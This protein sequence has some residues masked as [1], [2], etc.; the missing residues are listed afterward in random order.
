MTSKAPIQIDAHPTEP[1]PTTELFATLADSRRRRILSL[2]GERHGDVT[3]SELATLVASEE[4][5]VPLGAVTDDQHERVLVALKHDHLPALE[6]AGLVDRSGT[7]VRQAYTSV[8][9]R[10]TVECI[11][12]IDA[13]PE[14]TTTALDLLASERRQQLIQYL[15]AE[16]AATVDELVAAIEDPGDRQ[17]VRLSLVHTHL[18]KLVDASAISDVK[19]DVERRVVYDGLPV[20]EQTVERLLSARTVGTR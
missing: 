14:D 15:R 2:L 8:T 4:A 12:D 1:R 10:A 16:R 3:E 13:P 6:S 11:L 20:D 19:S 9:E 18:P 5:D 17:N 7:S